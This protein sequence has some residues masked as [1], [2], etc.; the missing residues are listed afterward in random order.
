MPVSSDI[1]G[2]IHPSD[3]A[4][5]DARR[6][7]VMLQQLYQQLQEQELSALSRIALHQQASLSV[8]MPYSGLHQPTV[9][10]MLES[11]NSLYQRLHPLGYP[12]QPASLLELLGRN[13]APQWPSSLHDTATGLSAMRAA[14]R[15]LSPLETIALASQSEQLNP[16]SSIYP[17]M[18]PQSLE[19]LII[20]E[21]QR[22][23]MINRAMSS[24]PIMGRAGMPPVPAPP[25]RQPSPAVL[26][27]AGDDLFIPA[28]RR[29]FPGGFVSDQRTVI[30]AIPDDRAKLNSQQV[31]L[32]HQIEVFRA[33]HDD[34][35]SHTRGR[36]KPVMLGQVGIRCRHCGNLPV[37]KRAKGSTYFPSS[38]TGIYQ[39]SQNLSVTH[40]QSGLCS[41]MPFE[42]KQQFTG[43]V[44]SKVASSGVGRP[45]W[46]EAARKLG[47]V[48]TPYGI[49]FREDLPPGGLEE[50]DDGADDPPRGTG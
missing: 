19:N 31:F 1:E 50:A 13:T 41:E 26:A 24:D 7:N 21:Q 18:Q 30:L 25:Q 36:N 8:G 29:Q 42:M 39:A 43:L 3:L 22:Q 12:P 34:I 46:A 47:L 9:A 48:D 37:A 33:S 32:R 17:N 28:L 35:L 27:P 44:S 2:V 38:V 6:D 4:G 5:G 15:G 49:R 40:L 45:Y 11:S 14:S 20:Q 10:S 16:Y 23:Q